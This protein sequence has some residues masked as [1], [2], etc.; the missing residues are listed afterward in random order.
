MSTDGSEGHFYALFERV[1]T[2]AGQVTTLHQTLLTSLAAA[3]QRDAV[4]SERIEGL[5]RRLN[6]MEGNLVTKDDFKIMTAA[7]KDDLNT[8]SAEVGRLAKAMAEGR[9][10]DRALS[11]VITQAATWGAL[12]VAL[13]ALVGVRPNL[14]K[15]VPSSTGEQPP[16]VGQ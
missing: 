4:N 8:L 16:V 1:G 9:G 10:K 12:V 2:L 3:Q 13:L 15:V 14:E 7:T 5:E 11:N 6:N